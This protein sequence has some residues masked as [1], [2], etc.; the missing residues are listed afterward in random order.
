MI[1]KIIHLR[2]EKKSLYKDKKKEKKQNVFEQNNTSKN[3]SN[4]KVQKKKNFFDW[5]NHTQLRKKKVI[6]ILENSYC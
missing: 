4:K 5:E 6:N 1:R 2:R 3:V